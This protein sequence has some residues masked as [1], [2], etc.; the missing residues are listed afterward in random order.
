MNIADK[1]RLLLKETID[2][3]LLAFCSELT[4]EYIS[5]FCGVPTTPNEMN[6]LASEMLA[7]A[8]QSAENFGKDVKSVSRGDYS[9]TYGDSLKNGFPRFNNRLIPFRKM[10]W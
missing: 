8:Y 3:S 2:E 6:N 10:K 4:E 9:V 1:A 5:N 7:F